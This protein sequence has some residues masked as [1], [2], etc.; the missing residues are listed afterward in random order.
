M[1]EYKVDSEYEG[2]RLD[3]LLKKMCKNETLSNL[4]KYIKNGNVKVNGKKSKENYRLMLNDIVT[5]KNIS[6]NIEKQPIKT[7]NID[8]QY[9]KDMIVYENENLFIINKPNGVPMHKGTKHNYGLSEVFK[10]IYNSN[11]VNF[12]NRLDSETSGLIIGCKNLKYLRYISDQ[13]KKN[14][15]TKKY[16][17]LV[18][19]N[20]KKNNYK[21][22]NYI[23]IMENKVKVSNSSNENNR[24]SITEIVK[25]KNINNYTLLDLKLITGRKHQI[26]AQLSNDGN[27]IL[28]DKKYGIKDNKNKLYLMCYYLKFDDIE[29]K[30]EYNEFIKI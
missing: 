2:A 11:N 22:E 23:E 16:V 9:Y 13:I 6:V 3:R 15:I 25:L 19:N 30:L 10:K 29:F 20:V 27:P 17:A 5:F 14:E 28:G 12:A 7:L 26:R 8:E 4:F 21:I 1:I 24:L 18:H